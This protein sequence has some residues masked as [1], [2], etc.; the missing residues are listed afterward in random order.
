M[1][2]NLNTSQL[3]ETYR[4]LTK[5][6]QKVKEKG[7]FL[8]MSRGKPA[9]DQL[10]LSDPMN[11]IIT[12]DI[13]FS[14]DGGLDVRN[15]GAPEGVP[16]A[17]EF[18]AKLFQV[19]TENVIVGGSSSLNLMFDA[20]G[21]AMIHG[22]MGSTPWSKLDKVKFLCPSPGYDRHFSITEYYNIEMI[23]IPML[24]DGPDMG[25]V[26]RYVEEDEA[27]KGI[28]CVPKY[29]NPTGITYSERVVNAFASLKPKAKDFRIFWDN[30]Y[31]VHD[32]FEADQL[33]SII[34]AC[35][36]AGNP[37]LVYQF[38]STSK[39]TYPGAGISAIVASKANIKDTLDKLSY[40]TICY[41]KVN[42]LRH[43]RFLRDPDD[44]A[45]HM[46]KHAVML[47]PKFQMVKEE[48]EKEL[49]STGV[50]QWTNPNGGY[51]I[52]VDV[53][54]GTAKRTVALC[55]EAGLILTGAGA[56]FPYGKDPEDKNIRIAP[57][58]PSVEELK[59]AME[60]FCLCV[61][62]AAVEKLMGQ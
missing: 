49:A 15:Y 54:P 62:L 41:D 1:Y 22:I 23:A 17:R 30:A 32:V 59:T 11:D 7:L 14:N 16:E 29:S 2:K 58:Y 19:E 50:A 48:L 10:A 34:K 40:Q 53:Y 6:Y 9:P 25:T 31:Y 60:L 18:F 56:T 42:Q 61:R 21:R 8:D 44:L 45:A 4:L 52:S 39:I 35:E 55:K 13:D 27:V 57:T 47:A 26:A 20:I 33:Y 28:W 38:A 46:K 37:D 12:S 36:E 3:K 43:V 51:F 24:E 5:E